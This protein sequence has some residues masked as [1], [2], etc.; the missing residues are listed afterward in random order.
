MRDRAVLRALA[1]VV[2]VVTVAVVAFIA[3]PAPAATPA[4]VRYGN[5]TFHVVNDVRADHDRGELRRS[6][7]LQ[8]FA[9]K[10][11]GR[12]AE[13]RR[14]S[15]QDLGRIQQRCGVGHVAENVAAGPGGPRVTVSRWMASDGHR[16]NIL[17]RA[18]RITGVA[19]RKAGGVWWVA[20]VFARRR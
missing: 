20:Q 10:Q 5:R 16:A 19:A 18:Y 11:A 6:R 12:M 9:A 2:A 17:G 7:C 1:A 3:S 15:H 14:L 13:Q 8:R 4:E